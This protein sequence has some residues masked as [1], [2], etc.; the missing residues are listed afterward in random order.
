MFGD[1]THPIIGI[2]MACGAIS[3]CCVAGQESAVKKIAIIKADDVRGVTK[4][5]KRFIAISKERKVKVSCGIIC[6]SL[7]KSK[8]DYGKWL[9]AE[10][11]SG[12]VEF[13]NHGW[14]HKRWEKDGKKQS[15]FGGSGFAHQQGH[16]AKSQEIMTRVIGVTPVA[17]GTPFNSFDE[18]TAK[19]LK[20]DK[21]IKLLFC[22]RDP[23]ID[24]V[25]AARMSLR[26]EPDGTGKP[27]A[28]KFAKDYQKKKGKITFA[29]IQFHPNSFR[30]DRHFDEYAKT[31]DILLKDG[32]TFMLPREYIAW[33][34]KK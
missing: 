20:E 10:E 29:A 27:N 33:L 9:V 3:S 8:Q 4:K 17:F 24:G 19:V 28:T 6:N 22:Y 12:F 31:L 21:G 5:W 32:W 11:K 23:K 15:E 14:D 30:E 34:A 1:K 26:G 16:F 2:L 25:I 7:E 18:D 13:W